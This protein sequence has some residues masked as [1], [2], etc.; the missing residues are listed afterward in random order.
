MFTTRF[1]FDAQAFCALPLVRRLYKALAVALAVF[2]VTL[3]AFKQ[4]FRGYLAEARLSGPAMEGL[5]LDE[6]V[7]W[8]KQ[9]DSQVAAVANGPNLRIRKSQ[10]RI[11]HVASRTQTAVDRVDGLA[12]RWL[13]QYL[14]DRLQAY[15]QSV[16]ADLRRVADAA[17]QQEDAAHQQLEMLRQAQLAEIR[18]VGFR[19]QASGQS[20]QGTADRGLETGNNA[21]APAE[22]STQV[23]SEPSRERAA[24]GENL[25]KLRL[26]VTR[27]AGQ[28]TEEHPE[29]KTLRSQVAT[30]EE[31]LGI[32]P[33]QELPA[34]SS[35]RQVVI[36]ASRGIAQHFVSSAPPVT[37]EASSPTDASLAVEV[38]AALSQLSR[39]SSE[40]QAA[41][42]RL[43]ERMHQLT[44]QGTASQW[45]KA[46]V[47][48]IARLG[49]TPRFSTLVLAGLLACMGGTVV[50][51]AAAVELSLPAIQS[52][53]EL[54]SALELPVVGNLTH[55]R[56]TA[57]RR[58][59]WRLLA[60]GRVRILVQLADI[61]IAIAV[62]AC[63]LSVAVEPGLVR[64]VIADPFGTLSEVM[65][66][67]G[68]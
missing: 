3:V 9:L 34:A 68:V 31:Q 5:D 23:A 45:S 14:P 8:I 18:A 51:R 65:G 29:V 62:G 19:V 41:E 48:T 6:A 67:F 15:R 32:L 37:R 22:S 39:A 53:A 20:G 1:S 64:Q 2:L 40:R 66:R 56:A 61:V 11:T 43:S 52:P 35:E 58:M 12:E 49:G 27:L 57:V 33:G 60:P 59:P 30:A 26:E 38:S 25:A 10:I 4:P 13:Y 55:L 46:A 21:N 47:T 44:G 36:S 28:R 50:F 42:S 24:L 54:A 7:A 16:L 63:L 17:R